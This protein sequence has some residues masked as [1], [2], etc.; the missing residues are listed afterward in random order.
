MNTSTITIIVVV[1]VV[2]VGVILGL[3]FSRRNRS[4]QFHE[5][6]RT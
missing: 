4:E 2:I 1:V 5:K 6:F 3:I